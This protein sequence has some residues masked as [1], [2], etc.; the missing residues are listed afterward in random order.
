MRNTATFPAGNIGLFKQ[1]LIA[2]A[3]N[4]F[5]AACFDYN[6]YTYFNP[7][8][9]FLAAAG[10]IEIMP[11][12]HN[13]F[14]SLQ[15]FHS[16]KKDWVFGFLSY[17]LKNET[18]PLVF[19]KKDQRH[20]G[21][22]FPIAYFFRPKHIIEIINDQIIVHSVED[23]AEIYASIMST[24]V[25]LFSSPKHN[26][27]KNRITR[28]EY[29]ET[30]VAI[31]EHIANGDLYEMNFC[32]E[33]YIDEIQVNPPTLFNALN[34]ISPSPFA[35]FVKHDS[36]YLLCASPERFL[37]KD[38][39]K[40]M[41]QPMKGTIERKKSGDDSFQKNKL[42]NDPKERAENVMIVDLVRNDLARSSVAGS[43]KVEELFGVYSFAQVHQMISTVTSE[44]QSEIDYSTAIKN[45]F[46]MGSMTGAPK[47]MAMQLID[48][49]E[50]VK[51]GL[52]SGSVGFIT[53][54]G[55]F[56]FNV[57]I[58]SIFYNA[59]TK[60]LSFQAG[61]A[62]TYDCEPE[63]EYEECMLKAKAIFKVLS[64]P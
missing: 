12:Y 52:F 7:Q 47:V 20:N 48:K 17:D 29:V 15:K 35:C 39:R 33:F 11:C 26:G 25:E 24:T 62:I 27:I 45:A 40:L 23:P 56:D 2:W 18:E 55:D 22:N 54:D 60:Y 19:N 41:S 63:K 37:K 42:I 57:V 28:E 46:P 30:V 44:L 4:F 34:K 10:E 58:R 43:V 51:R 64:N 16:E 14:S 31:K 49:Y 21:I 38:G 36:N 53:P 61:G 13:Y 5:S 8:R 3:G 32:Q 50:K 9:E 1:Q 59:S 6:G